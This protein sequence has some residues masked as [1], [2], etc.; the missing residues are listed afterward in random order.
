M[1][2]IMVLI[3][4][5]CFI[6]TGCS[7]EKK[8]NYDSET[9]K[10]IEGCVNLYEYY[11]AKL[12]RFAFETEEIGAEQLTIKALFFNNG[13]IIEDYTYEEIYNLIDDK[14]KI[15]IELNDP[16][17]EL[18]KVSYCATNGTAMLTKS[19][20]P[21]NEFISEYVPLAGVSAGTF[22]PF[23]VPFTMY[24]GFDNPEIQ[25]AGLA[26]GQSAF[27]GFLV[28]STIKTITGRVPPHIQ[29][30]IDGKEKYQDDYSSDFRWGFYR[31]GIK[32]GWPSGHTTVAVAMATTLVTMY[33]D[34]LAIKIGAVA[35]STFVGASMTFRAHW[36]SD[37]F[38]GAFAGFGIGRTV[39]KSFKKLKD[40]EYVPEQEKISLTYYGNGLGILVR[41]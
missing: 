6:I 17:G 34:N 35:Y 39:G 29:D 5:I 26:L 41:L 4:S 40:G 22:L 10:Y 18:F 8:L 3:L 25:L 28:S 13:E 19:S 20:S 33:P 15:W 12:C 27:Q 21:M 24:F 37:V 16:D 1:K 38:A 7:A 23:L 14:G 2:K 11:D 36:I 9:E 31:G 30:A 32:D